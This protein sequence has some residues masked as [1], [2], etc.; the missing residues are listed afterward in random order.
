MKNL[1]KMPKQ[2][3]ETIGIDLGD[4][5]G[6]YCMVDP[7]GEALGEGTFRNQASSLEI[8]PAS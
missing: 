8:G 7:D 4:N 5:V 6:R 2:M 1:C 3:P